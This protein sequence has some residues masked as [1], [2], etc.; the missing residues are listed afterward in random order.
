V[1]DV[2]K[3]AHPRYPLILQVLYPDRKELLDVTENLSEGGLFIRTDRELSPGQRVTIQ[4]TFSPLLPPIEIEA[5][6]VRRR[7]A[8]AELP[9]GVAVRLPAERL[10]LRQR[11]AELARAATVTAGPAATRR[12]LIVE[13]NVLLARMYSDALAQLGSAEALKVELAGD[14]D[15]AFTRLQNLPRIDLVV[16][17]RVMPRMDGISLAARIRTAVLLKE[18]PIVMISSSWDA[19]SEEQARRLGVNV[20]LRKPL[21]LQDLLLT[22]RSLL[23]LRR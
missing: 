16:T 21:K 11:L 8:T 13:D 4:L 19:A 17:D 23:N 5:E 20:L 12:V 1:N 14:G 9:A 3:R 10:D 15:V 2:D 7:G 6:V 22:L 18:L